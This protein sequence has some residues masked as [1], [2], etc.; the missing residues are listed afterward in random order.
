MKIGIIFNLVEEITKG[1]EIEKLAD[2]EVYETAQAIVK[3]LKDEHEVSMHNFEKTSISELKNY[4]LVFNLA[5]SN[6]G[7]N[8]TDY[9]IAKLLEDNNIP[10]TGCSSQSLHKCTDKVLTK[11]EL[12]KNNIRTPKFFLAKDISELSSMN[13]QF[14]MI[15]KPVFEDG[16]IGIDED[17]VVHNLKQLRKKTQEVIGLYKQPALIEEFIDGREINAAIIGN[18]QDTIAL[19]LSEIVF[20]LDENSP[21]ILS[22]K[23]KWVTDSHIYKNT[24]GVSPAP[25]DKNTE[26]EIIDIA[27]KAY[28]IMGCSDYSRVDFRV[29]D[30]TPYVLEV[31][32]NPCLNPDGAGL[33]RSAGASGLSYSQLI[34]VLVKTAM[35][36][37]VTVKT[38]NQEETN[39]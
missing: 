35:K 8:I 5:E 21:K 32:P 29:K 13:M 30:G 31:N 23:A 2:N 34:L 37:Y 25:I 24:V 18:G 39:E 1:K 12:M 19:P 3:A 4:D 20:N 9:E 10:F 17:S 11:I 7:S 27:L 15:I 14:P 36:R 28:R 26:K 6:I 22:F 38:V 33:V 16:S